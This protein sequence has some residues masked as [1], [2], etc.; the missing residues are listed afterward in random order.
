MRRR[1]VRFYGELKMLEL[2][3]EARPA[4]AL[5]D[6]LVRRL[7]EL[8]LRASHLHVPLFYS[9][10]LYTLKQHVRLVRGRMVE[11]R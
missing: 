1:I 10:V 5:T 11:G 6:D 8:E 4:D 9:Q 2:E 3:L 7:D